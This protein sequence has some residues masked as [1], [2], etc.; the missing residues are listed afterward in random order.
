MVNI[1]YVRAYDSYLRRVFFSDTHFINSTGLAINKLKKFFGTD[2]DLN[3]TTLK[4]V[5]EY[6]PKASKK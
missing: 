4:T 3:K 1:L 2:H 6:S 5:G